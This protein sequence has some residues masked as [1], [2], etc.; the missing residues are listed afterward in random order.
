[1]RRKERDRQLLRVLKLIKLFEHSRFGLSINEARREMGVTRRTIYRDLAMI[2]DAGYRFV[3]EGGGG[4]QAKKWRFPPGMRKAPDK[5]YTETELLSLYFCMNLLQPL[6]GTP[7][8]DGVESLVSKIEA[9]FPEEEREY[10]GD[11]VFTHVA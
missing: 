2:E 7:L 3:K 9:T 5:P 8:R 11:L 1:M 6:R 4:G 10:L